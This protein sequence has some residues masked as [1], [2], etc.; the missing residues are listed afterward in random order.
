M[1]MLWSEKPGSGDG[2]EWRCR[3]RACP[4]RGN[5]KLSIRHGSFFGEHDNVLGGHRLSLKQMLQLLYLWADECDS[6]EYIM[7]QVKIGGTATVVA[8]KSLCREICAEHFRRHPVVLGGAGM[9]VE[10]DE[11]VVSKPKYRRGGGLLRP[12]RWVFGM[13]EEQQGNLWM[14]EL[15]GYPSRAFVYPIIAEHVLPRTHLN[16]DGAAIYNQV[17]G[18][19]D[20][21]T[22][23]PMQYTHSTVNHSV[24]FRDPQTGTTTNHIECA[25]KN[26]KMKFKRMNGTS[27]GFLNSY[28]IEFMWRWNYARFRGSAFQSI[29]ECIREQ[30]PV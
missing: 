7:K 8:Q 9:V 19:M 15:P 17:N 16:T 12:Q 10:M 11:C 27:S 26:A 13:I 2:Y 4:G 1:D 14:E 21:V 18:I 22:Y 30:F 23:A 28:L 24:N 20:N 25:W 6:Q 29:L 5:L 3:R